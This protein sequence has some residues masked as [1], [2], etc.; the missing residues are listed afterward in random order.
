MRFE[1]IFCDSIDALNLFMKNNLENNVLIKTSSP[2]ILLNPRYKNT[3]HLENKIIGGKLKKFQKS[4]HPF[5]KEVFETLKKT[6]N[7]RISII[8]SNQA[9]LFQRLLRKVI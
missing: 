3:H 6:S 4:I 8:A 1:Q 9:T 5:T 7:Y 2:N